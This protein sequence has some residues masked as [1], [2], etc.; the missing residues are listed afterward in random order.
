MQVLFAAE[1][2]DQPPPGSAHAVRTSSVALLLEPEMSCLVP[3]ATV[4]KVLHVLRSGFPADRI[5]IEHLDGLRKA[6][7]ELNQQR[8][9]EDGP[10]GSEQ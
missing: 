1:E 2:R 9:P 10:K 8:G 3:L 7:A 5:D 4:D 6:M